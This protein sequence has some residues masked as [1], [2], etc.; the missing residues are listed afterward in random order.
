M[1]W[2]EELAKEEPPEPEKPIGIVVI[3]NLE[4]DM[5]VGAKELVRRALK[6]AGFKTVDLGGGVPAPDFAKKAKEV[7]ANIVAV[8]INTH[9]ALDN[10][11]SL[12]SALEAEGL[13]GKIILMLG[14]S[15]VKKEDADK[16]GALYGK[17]SE[18]AAALAKKVVEE[19]KA[20]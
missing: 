7:N 17:T 6:W 19:K 15:V 3:G 2:L 11:P 5:H 1:A 20:S 14:G 18:E 4:P 16:I 9:M 8:S 12:E 13:K 10:L